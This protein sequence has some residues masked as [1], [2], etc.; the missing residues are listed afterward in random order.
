LDF[1]AVSMLLYYE[2]NVQS[3]L[4]IQQVLKNTYEEIKPLVET[5]HLK[6]V[7]DL[8]KKPLNVNVKAQSLFTVSFDL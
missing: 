7:M 2:K 5:R 6:V 3:I 4:L 8:P 1:E